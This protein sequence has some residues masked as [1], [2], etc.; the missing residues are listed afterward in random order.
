MAII[1][2]FQRNENVINLTNVPTPNNRSYSLTNLKNK[3]K[4]MYDDE[5][6]KL[7]VR[8]TRNLKEKNK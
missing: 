2:H 1:K 7:L 8:R 6:H 4:N 5:T 3:Y